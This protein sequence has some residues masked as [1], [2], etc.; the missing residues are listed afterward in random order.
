MSEIAPP[1]GVITFIDI[2]GE[3]E[4]VQLVGP[5]EQAIGIDMLFVFSTVWVVDTVLV[6]VGMGI[7][8]LQCSQR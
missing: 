4:T 1:L 3:A 8:F 2:V 6:H 7:L 5:L